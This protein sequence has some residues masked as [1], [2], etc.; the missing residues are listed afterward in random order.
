MKKSLHISSVHQSIEES[1]HN[2]STAVKS[3]LSKQYTEEKRVYIAF[4][5]FNLHNVKNV[6]LYAFP[7]IC[8]F[9]RMREDK[10]LAAKWLKLKSYI[11][12]VKKYIYILKRTDTCC[13]YNTVHDRKLHC[14]G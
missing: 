8:T 3:N 1:K 11:M 7:K 4:F 2:H 9:P 14:A 6:H 12:Q 13:I 10:R 5:F